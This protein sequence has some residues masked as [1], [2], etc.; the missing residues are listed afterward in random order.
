[1]KFKNLDEDV[2]LI[3]FSE[4]GDPSRFSGESFSNQINEFSNSVQRKF[5][6][7]GGWSSDHQLML[8]SFLQER[9]LMANVV[10]NSNQ[11][12]KKTKAIS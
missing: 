12:I 11:S 7:M 6:E 10:K 1:M 3:F 2:N 5:A 8:N 4:L 9:F